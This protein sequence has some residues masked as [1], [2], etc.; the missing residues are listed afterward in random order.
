MDFNNHVDDFKRFVVDNNII[1]TSAGVCV[2]LAAKD[3]I[4]SFVGDIIIP[5]IVLLL[6]TLRIG[7]LTK[8][9]PIKGNSGFDVGSFIKQF[10]TFILIIIIS[11]LFVKMTFGYLLGIE[12]KSKDLSSTAT[13]TATAAAA[14]TSKKEKFGMTEHFT[15]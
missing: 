11:F 9:L 8:F 13:A 2:A 12:Q 10:V 5:A 1:G 14:T 7:S 15:F 4:Q 6:H 3:G